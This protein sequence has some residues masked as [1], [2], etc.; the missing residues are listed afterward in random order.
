MKNLLVASLLF[1][2]LTS[3]SHASASTLDISGNMLIG[4]VGQTKIG[5]HN[6]CT[7]LVGINVCKDSF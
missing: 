1:A 5:A 7:P 6:T 2:M 3:V 4:L